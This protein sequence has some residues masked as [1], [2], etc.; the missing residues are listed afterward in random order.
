[1]AKRAI[2]VKQAEERLAELV[3]EASRGKDVVLTRDGEPVARIVPIQRAKRVRR[4]GSAKGKVVVHPDF[5]APLEEF[6]DYM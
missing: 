6:R 1:M 4:F 5:D 2:D 3:D